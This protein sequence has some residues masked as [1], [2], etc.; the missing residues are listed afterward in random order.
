MSAV[1][2]GA[3]RIMGWGFAV[4]AASG[5]S[6]CARA[7]FRCVARPAVA[8]PLARV[9]QPLHFEFSAPVEPASIDAGGLRVVRADDGGAVRGRWRCDGTTVT[10]EPAA[11][12]ASDLADV[13]LVPGSRIRIEAI[14]LPRLVALRSR[15]GAA[16][17]EGFVLELAAAPATAD[18]AHRPATELFFDPCPGP[19]ALRS[20]PARL[21]AGHLRLQFS[22]PLDPRT[23]ATTR[24]WLHGPWSRNS[25]P[26]DN[27]SMT[28]TLVENDDEA[29]IELALGT[30]ALPAPLD[31]SLR[32]ELR[33]EPADGL[34]DLGGHPLEQNGRP[35]YPYV[36]VE[37][38]GR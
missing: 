6:G 19:P 15:E 9:N 20:E 36:K 1:R 25:H 30:D 16:L 2:G 31:P 4:L 26:T 17:A 12:R 27:P 23:V 10:F 11:P 18:F 33:L 38:A 34:R 37:F 5:P 8:A 32:L 22:E 24:F 21:A 13:A 35:F 7:P 29:V 14:G 28:A 3:R